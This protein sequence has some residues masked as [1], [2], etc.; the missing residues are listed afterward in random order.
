MAFGGFGDAALLDFAP[1]EDWVAVRED[2]I[3]AH[4]GGVPQGVEGAGVEVAT[5]VDLLECIVDGLAGGV[6]WAVGLKSADG[7]GDVYDIFLAA[8]DLVDLPEQ[9]APLGTQLTKQ[10]AV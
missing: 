4:L 1:L 10:A 6:V 8:H 3:G 9:V 2:D 7:F 5:E